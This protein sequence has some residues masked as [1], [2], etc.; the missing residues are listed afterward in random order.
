MDSVIVYTAEPERLWRAL[1]DAGRGRGRMLHETHPEMGIEVDEARLYVT[2]VAPGDEAPNEAAE[3]GAGV[4]EF[5][6]D[7]H[8]AWAAE[9][10]LADVIEGM[11]TVVDDDHGHVM[12]GREFID[13]VRARQRE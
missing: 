10:F 6:V 9:R 3:L 2:E 13:V 5:V 11:T 12:D 1:A 4:R 7:V 8:N